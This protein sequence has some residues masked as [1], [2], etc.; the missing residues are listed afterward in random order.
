MV[1]PF[2]VQDPLVP[3]YWEQT[4]DPQAIARGDLF[5]DPPES[6]ELEPGEAVETELAFPLDP[7]R[8]PLL[9]VRVLIEGCQ[10]RFRQRAWVWSAFWYIDTATLGR[11]VTASEQSGATMETR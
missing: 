6:I 11:V 5:S 10:G 2:A 8:A 7:A 3:V 1:I 9:A 4:D